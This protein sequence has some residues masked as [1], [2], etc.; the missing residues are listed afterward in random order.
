MIFFSCWHELSL[1]ARMSPFGS[2]HLQFVYDIIYLQQNS[3]LFD[4]Y[5]AYH[6]NCDTN[7]KTFPFHLNKPNTIR[8]FFDIL[9]CQGQMTIYAGICD[10]FSPTLNHPKKCP[11]NFVKYRNNNFE[12]DF[13]LYHQIERDACCIRGCAYYFL[14]GF[15]N[16]SASFMAII[17]G[18][19]CR[20]SSNCILVDILTS[21]LTDSPF[22]LFRGEKID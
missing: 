18:K 3:T 7:Y 4:H 11:Y 20:F 21:K 12:S 15:I 9:Q 14:P 8:Q 1:D 6:H 2:D 5:S 17:F 19:L 13:H 16:I 22:F 10:L